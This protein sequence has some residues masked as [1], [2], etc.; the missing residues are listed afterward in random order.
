MPVA[1]SQKV[2]SRKTVIEALNTLDF[3]GKIRAFRPNNIRTKFFYRDLIDVVEAAGPTLTLSSFP[4]VTA[5]K[6]CSLLIAF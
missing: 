3:G 2:E 4:N 6:I 1:V 5:P